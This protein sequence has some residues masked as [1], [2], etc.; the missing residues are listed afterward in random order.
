MASAVAQQE[1]LVIIEA[2]AALALWL[3]WFAGK[4]KA[5]IW[6]SAC[7]PVKVEISDGSIGHRLNAADNW[8]EKQTLDMYFVHIPFWRIL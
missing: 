5:R 7:S 2:L 3:L 1:S 8:R 6:L 4:S